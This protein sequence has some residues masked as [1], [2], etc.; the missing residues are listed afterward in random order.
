MSPEATF[1]FRGLQTVAVPWKPHVGQVLTLRANVVPALTR[2]L[3]VP[4]VFTRPP[5]RVEAD[6]SS[7]RQRSLREKGTTPSPAAS[8]AA[9]AA[10]SDLARRHV[11][12][13]GQGLA[14]RRWG[15]QGPLD[16]RI[17][18]RRAC[19]VGLRGRRSLRR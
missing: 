2:E 15:A 4:T 16:G 1:Y 3:C 11:E 10:A 9:A 8:A 12:D 5:R 13:E 7:E 18:P 17:F 6:L 19:R 14:S